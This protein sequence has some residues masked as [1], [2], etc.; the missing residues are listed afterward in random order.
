MAIWE[1]E[2]RQRSN[3]RANGVEVCHLMGANGSVRSRTLPP[4]ASIPLERV[5][6]SAGATRDDL[7]GFMKIT[8]RSTTRSV[9]DPA[10]R[11]CR[12]RAP[13]SGGTMSCPGTAHARHTHRSLS[14]WRRQ[15]GPPRVHASGLLRN[16]SL[17]HHVLDLP[18]ILS[19]GAPQAIRLA[20]R[21]S[22]PQRPYGTHIHTVFMVSATLPREL[23]HAFM[24]TR[25]QS[26]VFIV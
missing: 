3:G 16:V 25:L 11:H 26:V 7:H 9:A 20:I 22:H 23:S 13:P 24:H 10:A 5:R 14:Y 19:S 2:A 8:T 4:M 21:A 17:I 1:R 15:S 12:R 6:F 18:S